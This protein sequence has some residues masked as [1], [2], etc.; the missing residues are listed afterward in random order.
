M[1]ERTETYLIKFAVPPDDIVS[2][3]ECSTLEEAE[4]FMKIP[5]EESQVSWYKI[6][7]IVRTVESELVV[8]N[9]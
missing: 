6:Y 9:G 7:R 1:E 3:A 4:G 8:S 2:E 5:F